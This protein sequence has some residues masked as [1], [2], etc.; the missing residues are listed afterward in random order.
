MEIKTDLKIIKRILERGVEKVIKK[1]D[2]SRKL[3]KGKQLRIKH[4]VDPTTKDLHLGYSVIYLKLKDFQDLGHKIVFLVGDFTGR[5]G[6]PTEKL[7]ARNLRSKKEVRGLA[8][9]YLRQVGKILDLKKTEI[10]YNSE[11]YDKMSAEDLLKLMSYFTTDRMMERDIFR[12]RKKRKQETR[13]H[14]PVY[15]ALQAYDSVKLEADLT[16]CGIDQ[17]FN[18]IKG[19]EIQEKMGQKPQDIVATELLIGTDGKRKMS[20]SLGNYI[21]IEEKPENQYG[22]IMSIP[23]NLIISYFK[24]LTRISL[25]KIEKYEKKL[26]K[27]QVNPR[28]L[29]SELAKEIVT[30]YYGEKKAEKVEKEFNRVFKEKKA[31]ED[32]PEFEI[33][34][35]K[36][37]VLDLL[38]KVNL[39]SSK[40]EAKRLVNQGG[41][42]IDRELLNDWKKEIDIKKGM[43][44]KVGKRNFIKIK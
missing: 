22:K 6:D 24:L 29:K 1:E 11:W 41:V 19:R 37:S 23:D 14:E 13:F 20:Q 9:N 15:P 33:K 31:P 27:K 5:F 4:G 10:R 28:E 43:L 2:L 38:V 42:T 17:I 21:G 3:K 35:K 44:I 8:K 18:E 34:E 39:A 25:N 7:E 40:S 36:L 26:S 12:E 32:I 16:V 30:F